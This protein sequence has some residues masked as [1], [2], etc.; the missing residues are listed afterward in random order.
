M[1]LLQAIA[2]SLLL[3]MVCGCK[4]KGGVDAG[5]AT[6]T[7]AY[8]N[9]LEAREGFAT[10]LIKKDADGEPAPVPPEGVLQLVHYTGPLGAMP[11]YI[12]PRPADGKKRPAI[13]WIT[14]GYSNSIGSKA[15]KSPP[16]ADESAGAFREAGI[17]MMYPS[18]RGGNDS[19]GF[20]ECFYGEVNDV[21]AA[22]DYLAK[23]DYVDSSRIYLAGHSTGGT[24]TM[25]VD[26]CTDRFRAV[27][28]FGT[29]DDV[30]RYGQEPMKFD[31]ADA[32][33]ADLRSPVKWLY[34]IH[35]PTFV[36]EGTVKPCNDPSMRG[37]VKA[38]R[39]P[40]VHLLRA[41]GATHFSILAP[42][43]R[44]I[45]QKILLDSGTQVNITF[46]ED[47]ISAPFGR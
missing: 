12:T 25:L 17:V 18:L 2:V 4:G 15:W 3:V 46:S 29:I 33:E 5:D 8:A 28:A 43:T 9:L 40:L 20:M 11:A 1:K 16:D 41:R 36:F 38:C 47:E 42:V 37:L 23:L 22:A 32:K 34:A 45:A 24:L 14:G 13:I 7:P 26:E 21:L 30:R 35:R 27:F 19:P 44:M 31:L 39:N 10:K 6:V